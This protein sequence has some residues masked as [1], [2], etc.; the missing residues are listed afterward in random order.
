MQCKPVFRIAITAALAVFPA[1]GCFCIEESLSDTLAQAEV[2]FVGTVGS[3]QPDFDFWDPG[4][5]KLL[6]RF[7]DDGSP[8][9]LAEFKRGYLAVIP[10]P[11]RDE[12]A[13]ATN[14]DQLNA[15]FGKLNSPKWITLT[16][17]EAF[18]GVQAGS[19]VVR[20]RTSFFDCGIHFAKSETYLVYAFRDQSALETGACSR[21]R[22]VSRARDDLARLR[23]R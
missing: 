2:V 11:V 21:T 10:E 15:A 19:R 3:M 1:S 17:L 13:Q 20:L 12:V 18:K 5:K 6:T 16:V 9:A 4:V 14:R 8:L 7:F 22:P 23:L